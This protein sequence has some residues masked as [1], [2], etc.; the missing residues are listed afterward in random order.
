M[1]GLKAD[2]RSNELQAFAAEVPMEI[3]QD[4]V[5]RKT[6]AEKAGFHLPDLFRVVG[7][8]D[9]FETEYFRRRTESAQKQLDDLIESKTWRI[10]RRLRDLA[11]GMHGLIHRR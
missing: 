11:G 9:P 10:A 5:R 3:M 7:Q 8:I 1:I 2:P 4:P 6:L